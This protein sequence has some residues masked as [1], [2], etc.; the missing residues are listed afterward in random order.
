MFSS[1]PS[2]HSPHLHSTPAGIQTHRVE[3]QTSK[4]EALHLQSK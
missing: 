2:R 1:T 4:H 3:E